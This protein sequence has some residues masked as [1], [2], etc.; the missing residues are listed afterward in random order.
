MR[1]LSLKTKVSLV[2]PIISICVLAGILLL[3]QR[4]LESRVKEGVSEQQYQ[5]VSVL[6]DEIDRQVASTSESLVAI[7][8]MAPPETISTPQKA[9]EFLR[10]QSEHLA[11]FDNGFFIFDRHGRLMAELPRGL[12]R[13]GKDFSYRD[14]LKKTF[15]TR[16]PIISDPYV[17]SQEHHHS[18]LMFTAPVFDEGGVLV[19]VVGGGIDLTRSPFLGKLSDV[20]IGK[21]GYLYVVNTDRVTLFHSDPQVGVKGTPLPGAN[22]L[23]DRAIAGFDGT[24]ETI[25]SRGVRTLA[26]F[27]H[28]KSKNWIIAANYPIAQAYEPIQKANALFLGIVVPIA[29]LAALLLRRVL[30]R[31]TSPILALTRHVETL[32]TKTGAD[33]LFPSV[34]DDEPAILAQAFNRL[35]KE[36]DQQQEELAKREVLYRTVVDFSS[37]MVFWVAPDRGTMHYVSPSCSDVTGY[38][39]EEFYAAPGLLSSII[40]PDDREHWD[41]QYRGGA[42][43]DFVEP[44]EFRIVTKNGEIR[45]TNY[46]SRPVFGQNSAYVGLRG[47]FSD[48]TLLKRAKLSTI[49][50]E[51]KFRLFFEQS[52]DAIFIIHKDGRIFEVNNE[53]C[54]RYGFH[55]EEFIGMQIGDLDTPEYF[56]HNP[57]RFALVMELGQIT[58][59]TCHRC[60]SSVTL[61]V[62]VKARL[63]DFNGDK[64]IMAV[65]RDISDRKRAEELLRRQNEYLTAFHE[66]SLGLV[67]RLDVPSLLQAILVRAG[68]LVGTEHCYV[69]L[70]N[71]QG[72]AMDMVYQSGV[73]EDFVHRP[74][75]P[76][77]GIAGWVW[78]TG[79]PFHVDNYSQWE[80]RLPDAD[81][82]VLRAMVGVPL[83]SNNR[84]IGVLGLAF[85]KDGQLF[86]AEH[87][88]I[89][90]QFAE[91]ASVALDNAQLY[92]AVQRELSERQKAEASLRKLTVGVEQNPASIIITD[93]GGTIEYVNPRF[94]EVTGYSSAEAVGQNTRM[95]KSGTT[96]PAEYRLLWETI[97]GGREWRGEFHNRKKS[98]ELY[99]EQA[100]IAPIRDENGLITHFIAINEDITDRKQLESELHH[101]QKMEAIGQLAGGIA[102]DFNN[103]LTAVIG[104]ASIMQIKLPEESPFR[105]GVEQILATAE[106]GSSLTKGLLA[107]SRKQHT[108]TRHINLNEIVERVQ[109][110][111]HRLISEDIHLTTR[112]AVEELPVMVDSVQIEQVVMSLAANARDAMPGGGE[113]AI[114][115][116]LVDLDSSF[117][118]M[119]G[120]GQ[121][122]RFAV[123]AVSDTGQGMDEETISHIFE[124]FF[125][126]KGT[127][128]GTGLGLS[129]AYGIVKKHNGCIVC[130]SEKGRGTTFRI[131]LP[132]SD[133]EPKGDEQES[134]RVPPQAGKQ[135]ILLADDNESTRRFSREVLEEFGY[136]VIEAEDGQQALDRFRENREQVGLLILDV[137]MPEMKG[138]EV[139]EVIRAGNPG[140]KVLFTSGYTEEIVR[141]QEVLDESL[142]FIAKPYMPKELL[143]KIR[144]VL[145][146]GE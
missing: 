56:P 2:Y 29:L 28:L 94:S 36:A 80:H 136:A 75:G 116:A 101:S 107:F 17:S 114:E 52:S 126:T 27:K 10:G 103:I 55:R 128:K 129:I 63:I 78:R 141:S 58:F 43:A 79:E 66:T 40:H 97:L 115:S 111:L 35:L 34:G 20:K 88:A 54:N 9:L 47:S 48:I 21:N 60:R 57:E 39:P 41:E 92:D 25:T 65:A 120:L 143:M 5:I 102:H 125:T 87:M 145:G 14:Y 67:R 7:A 105:N 62:E 138:R 6:A 37:E 118:V 99:W 123:L 33:R 51:A 76:H 45:W 100:L 16:K 4:I 12:E 98:G 146:H 31:L 77:D 96:S 74:I 127:G 121:P 104:Y 73:F 23:L 13:S 71:E 32:S 44:V 95:F 132:C 81:R 46:L 84:V 93:T 130:T 122:G 144:E 30:S 3:S 53:A 64:A 117:A 110:L 1:T 83:K 133:A 139:Y 89:L 49:A 134:P 137:I 18:A 19:A 8:R 26:S 113:I 69:Y 142:P 24:D 85:L 140:V 109:K 61:P 70:L 131:Y 86:D 72:S 124:P 11:T 112:L 68:K 135:V 15:A 90:T 22:P 91:L 119:N 106:R 59:E 82:M 42:T 38:S 50:S 108:I